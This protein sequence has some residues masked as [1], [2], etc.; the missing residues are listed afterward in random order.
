MR[1]RLKSAC[2]Y[3]QIGQGNDISVLMQDLGLT[4]GNWLRWTQGMEQPSV[5]V[6]MALAVGMGVNANWLETGEGS[7][8]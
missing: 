5:K 1:N 4:S 8:L 7:M 3:Y 2:A 6:L